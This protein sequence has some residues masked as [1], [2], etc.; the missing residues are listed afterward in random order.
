MRFSY[1]CLR[2]FSLMVVLLDAVLGGTR[3]AIF[4]VQDVGGGV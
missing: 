2:L 3:G 1:F 4:Q